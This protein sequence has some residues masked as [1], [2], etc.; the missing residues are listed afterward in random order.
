MVDWLKDM[1]SV[2]R[3]I[4]KGEMTVVMTGRQSGKSMILDME[5]KGIEPA[6]KPGYLGFFT[7]QHWCH[8]PLTGKWTY[9]NVRPYHEYVSASDKIII[10]DD[11]GKFHWYKDREQGR[12]RELNEQELK[13][14]TFVMLGAEHIEPEESNWVDISQFRVKQARIGA[15]PCKEI[16]L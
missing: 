1:Q 16:L 3:G 10:R 13:D 4:R 15:N 11:E 8:N 7:N 6:F 2:G 5:S 9:H 14:L 12:T